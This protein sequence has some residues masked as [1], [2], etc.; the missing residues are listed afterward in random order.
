LNL[1]ICS[2]S[3]NV[4][5]AES[6]IDQRRSLNRQS[7]KRSRSVPA[8]QALHGPVH[9]SKLNSSWRGNTMLKKLP[10]LLAAVLAAAAALATAPPAVAQSKPQATENSL[11][12][13]GSMA[14]NFTLNYFDGN[15]LKSVSLEQYR[16][17]KN[18]V[19]AFF[20]FAFTG[21]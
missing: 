19:L 15:D 20:V 1:P 9:R 5:A 18:V 2:H 17:K 6:L 14:P 3:I 8:Q 4:K 12:K 7:I 16:G 11:P 10:R 21:G 13:V